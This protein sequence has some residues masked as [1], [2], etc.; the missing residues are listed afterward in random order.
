[1]TLRSRLVFTVYAPPLVPNDARPPEVVRGMEQALSGL[2]MEWEI[3]KE[4]NPIAL[5]RRDAW[6]GE[7]A[8]RKKF[9]LLCNGDESYAITVGGLELPASQSPGHKALLSIQAKL[10]LDTR[11]I[12]CAAGMLA[13]IAESARGFW[14]HAS[15]KNFGVEISEQLRRSADGPELSPRGL[16]MLEMPWNIRSPVTPRYIGWLNYWSEAAA[17]AI[18]F[19]DAAR[20]AEL[21]SRSRRTPSGGWVVQL[22]E[23]PLDYDN[24]EHI[25]ALRRAYERFPAIGGRDSR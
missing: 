4:G 18:G 2:R 20:D 21:L 5:P 22:T 25:E 13:S 14:G 12:E 15:Q 10:P 24:P 23:A 17:Q 9:P 1:M 7:A 8:A 6:L 19:P 16:P 3:S 11:V